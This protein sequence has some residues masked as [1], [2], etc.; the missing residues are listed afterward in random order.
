M[1]WL[2]WVWNWLK[3]GIPFAQWKV[4]GFILLRLSHVVTCSI[5]MDKLAEEIFCAS[6]LST[7]NWHFHQGVCS[8]NPR[9]MENEPVRSRRSKRRS[10][11]HPLENKIL[12]LWIIYTL[13]VAPWAQ[14]TIGPVQH[15]YLHLTVVEHKKRQTHIYFSRFQPFRFR[16]RA[17]QTYMA[18]TKNT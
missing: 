14:Q 4:S 10:P 17:I 7:V 15:L 5:L 12:K 9:G 2:I 16:G 1:D 8:C 11:I 18:F 3:F 6:R 13:V